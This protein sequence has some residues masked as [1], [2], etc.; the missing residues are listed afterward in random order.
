MTYLDLWRSTHGELTVRRS[1]EASRLSRKS[2]LPTRWI[3][4]SHEYMERGQH[5]RVDKMA[6]VAKTV[7]MFSFSS[8]NRLHHPNDSQDVSLNMPRT[9]PEVI[10]LRTYIRLFSEPERW[11]SDPYA[12]AISNN[13]G[14][15]KPVHTK[16]CKIL[17]FYKCT[18]D[19]RII[20]GGDLVKLP[21]FKSLKRLLCLQTTTWT[22]KHLVS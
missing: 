18:P 1:K 17:A 5:I 6:S 7:P 2:L 11:R 21:V 19:D 16:I 4:M 12:Q 22:N 20:S 14:P 9:C 3:T 10:I 15:G 8:S 13:Y